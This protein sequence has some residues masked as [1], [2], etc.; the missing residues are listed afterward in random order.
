MDPDYGEGYV[1]GRITAVLLQKQQN[2]L[3]IGAAS[4]GIWRRSLSPGASFSPRSDHVQSLSIGCL[5]ADPN[6]ADVLY[7][8]TGEPGR[9]MWCIDTA[10]VIQPTFVLTTA[11]DEAIPAGQKGKGF[12]M[13]SR[14]PARGTR[15]TLTSS[16]AAALR[17]SDSA[18]FPPGKA[19]AWFGLAAGT[20][21]VPTPVT[22]TA[23]VGRVAKAFQVVVEP[24]GAR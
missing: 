22:I 23:T 1:V 12:A 13:F 17:V 14:P 8:G 21:A 9:G 2:R 5:A 20:V 15:V 18:L 7:A 11:A 19:T 16:N 6:N 3:F 10:T 24:R 4:G